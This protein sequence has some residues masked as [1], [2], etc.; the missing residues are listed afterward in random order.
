ME[1][2]KKKIFVDFD[3]TLVNTSKA[4]CEIYNRRYEGTDGWSPANYKDSFYWNY[5][6]SCPLFTDFE[7]KNIFNE[8]ELFDILEPMENAV[9]ILE[10]LATTYEINVVT[11]G[12]RENIKQKATW[13]G[14][15]QFPMITDIIYFCSETRHTD[16]SMF[17][18]LGGIF[19]DDHPKNLYTSNADRRFIFGRITTW[20]NEADENFVRLYDWDFVFKY[21]GNK[22]TVF[23]SPTT[24]RIL[25]D[26]YSAKPY[27][28]IES[29]GYG[30]K[31]GKT[32][33]L[34]KYG[35]AHDLNIILLKS[36]LVSN[37]RE[38]YNY[39]KIFCV[40]D[41]TGEDDY[42]IDSDVPP[43]KYFHYKKRP[44]AGFLYEGEEER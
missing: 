25:N 8:K 40:N 19:I 26:L 14:W 43:V 21:I 20:N 30:K 31:A 32:F 18:M 29:K 3:D 7:R 35:I 44:Y 17:N 13:S 4:V 23:I 22:N 34:I 9:L 6:D 11:I 38:K 36:L 5:I 42:V 33:C 2:K 12:T 16:K 39:D 1:K 24:Q 28:L 41:F 27:E 37:L 15:S 10:E